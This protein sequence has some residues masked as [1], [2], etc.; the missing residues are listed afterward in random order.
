MAIK[1][2]LNSNTQPVWHCKK[3]DD[4]SWDKPKK[5]YLNVALNNSTQVITVSG[6]DIPQTLVCVCTKKQS[7]NFSVGDRFYYNKPVPKTHNL[8][9]NKKV[10]ANFELAEYATDSPNT[11]VIVLRYLKGR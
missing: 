6:V 2:V 9:Q 3:I 11:S 4:V 5:Y 8:L 10:D 7:A 1:T